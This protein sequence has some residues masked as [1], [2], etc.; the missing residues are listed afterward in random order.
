MRILLVAPAVAPRYGSMAFIPR[1]LSSELV[2]QGHE[3]SIYTTN[4]DGSQHLAVPVDCPV[5]AGGVKTYYF[6]GWNLPGNY[7][8]SLS[9]WRALCETVAS[10]DIVHSWSVYGFT[11]TAT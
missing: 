6:R 7:V 4:V 5:V 1:E 10:F 9:L 2:R 3:V 8:V 11:T